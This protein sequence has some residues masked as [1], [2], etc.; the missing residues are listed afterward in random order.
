VT[1]FAGFADR[2]VD[3]R[4]GGTV[5]IRRRGTG[6]AL[7]LLHGFPETHVMWH[8]LAP[9][10]AEH[11]TVLVA[12]LPGYGASRGRSPDGREDAYSKRAMADDLVNV[13][14]AEGFE[15]FGVVGHDRGARVAY[16]MALDHPARVDRLAVLDIVPT[17]DVL[18]RADERVA[19]SFWPWFLLAQPAPLPERLIAANP[20][21]IVDNALERWGSDASAFPTDV[22]NAYIDALRDP[23]VVHTV[24]EEYR[25]AVTIDRSED[26]EDRH[27]GRLI[28]CPTLAL[29]AEGGSVDTW[30]E[31]DGGPLEL[32]RAW[33]RS[34]TGRAL[35][36]GH[37]FPEANP[38]A[39]LAE[40]RAFFSTASDTHA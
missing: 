15:R 13:M 32:W 12:D 26:R 19:R 7:V 14:E 18:D 17:C 27:A 10:L 28:E 21:A 8:A 29:W 9:S 39:T 35:A 30:Y 37:F 34:V 22:R 40:L 24:C 16:R 23:S 5:F 25:A 1:R 33:A 2:F 36:G 38:A 4:H 6:P 20:D 31:E 11:F 3:V